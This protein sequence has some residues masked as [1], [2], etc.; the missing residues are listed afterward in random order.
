MRAGM[1]KAFVKENDEAEEDSPEIEAPALPE[2]TKNY[3]TPKGHERL[4]AELTHLLNVERP[5]ITEVVQWA[6]SLGDRSENADYIYGKRRLREIDRRIRF[7][8]KRLEIAEIVDPVNTQVDS[9]RFGATV[10]VDWDGEEE[11]TFIIVG[12]DETDAKVGRISWISPLGRALLKAKVGDTI[13]FRAP[14]GEVDVEIL[15]IQYVALD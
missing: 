3:M 13:T 6:A 9:V 8:T 15:E 5:K 14:K 11:K 1:S 2:G 7:L 4:R 12:I 10:R